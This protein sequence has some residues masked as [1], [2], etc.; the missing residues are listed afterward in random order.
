VIAPEQAP[1]H[2]AMQALSPAQARSVV[3]RTMALPDY[4]WRE[5][6]QYLYAVDDPELWSR[7]LDRMAA[8]D[9]SHASL[10]YGIGDIGARVVPLLVEQL[11][12][13]GKKREWREECGKAIVVALCRAAVDD[14]DFP[15]E[16]DRL[17]TFGE[18]MD[19][20][21]W[22]SY[23][24]FAERVLWKLPAERT[25]R[26]LLNGL[27]SS[28]RAV[29]A[30]AFGLIGHALTPAVVDLAMTGLLGHEKDLDSTQL[31]HVRDG[32]RSL[33]DFAG[34]VRWIRRSGGGD[35]LAGAFLSELGQDVYDKLDE[36]LKT[37]GASVTK[38]DSVERLRRCAERTGGSQRIYVLRKNVPDS[39]TYNVIGGTAPGVDASR[40]PLG[41]GDE[42]MTHLF[43]LDTATMPELTLGMGADT[44]TV[45]VF[46]LNPDY[47]EAL[48][49]DNDCTAVVCS[50]EE[51][52][53]SAGDPPSEIEQ[54]DREYF[55]AV[56][57]DV[58]P[59]VW[60]LDDDEY[61]EDDE[62]SGDDENEGEAESGAALRE[63]R[64]MIYQAS[65]RVLG[66]EIWL[67]EG[68]DV[69]GFLMQF[70][71]AFCPMNLGDAG[72]MYV[73]RDTAYWQ[74]H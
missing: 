54:I 73:Y 3:E 2:A 53:A 7:F 66:R 28:S 57:C 12:R 70:D 55:E 67:Q 32:L 69:D 5:A 41:E 9:A 27:A 14:G 6:A 52:L 35:N 13:R 40:W 59:D 58:D 38:V 36:E 31:Q 46:C 49:P 61:D 33:G 42:P 63:L 22:A 71:S 50:T 11:E 74:C 19:G 39:G 15:E 48:F 18:G 16:F 25:E 34:W 60:G 24:V 37:D 26:I 44:R 62:D 29:F 21:D 1:L 65:A 72:I 45:S 23:V 4:R 64:G 10:W 51:Q 43:T 20:D 68:E 17:F 30:R 56:A 47:N 8:E